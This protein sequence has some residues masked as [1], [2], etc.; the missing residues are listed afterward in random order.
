MGRGERRNNSAWTDCAPLLVDNILMLLEQSYNNTTDTVTF[1]VNVS[2]SNE[3]KRKV[4]NIQF[5]SLESS[6]ISLE[7]QE[8][9]GMRRQERIRLCC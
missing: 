5:C 8:T 2:S 1:L 4:T 3:D 7:L 9:L 6:D